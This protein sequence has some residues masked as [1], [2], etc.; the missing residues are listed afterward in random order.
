MELRRWRERSAAA[1]EGVAA[2][3]ENWR[4]EERCVRGCVGRRL[5]SPYHRL[6]DWKG[7][8]RLASPYRLKNIDLYIP[9]KL[10]IARNITTNEVANRSRYSYLLGPDGRFRNP[11]NQG[12]QRNC[13]DF[14]VNGSFVKEAPERD[15]ASSLE[16][17]TLRMF[18]LSDFL[19]HI[20]SQGF[21]QVLVYVVSP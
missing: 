9:V 5:G 20:E 7:A 13:T 11:Y 3:G 12:C 16:F 10:Q 8:E 18:R 15:Y 14:L 4:M 17:E 21:I 19:G 6:G 2:A 1:W